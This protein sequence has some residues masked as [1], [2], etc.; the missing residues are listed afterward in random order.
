MGCFSSLE[1]TTF[2]SPIALTSL[3][4]VFPFVC[5]FCPGLSVLLPSP[6]FGH[7]PSVHTHC[8]KPLSLT[9]NAGWPLDKHV[10][11]LFKQCSNRGYMQEHIILFELLTV[12][13]ELY[14]D[15][16]YNTCVNTCSMSVSTNTFGNN[17]TQQSSF[18]HVVHGATDLNISTAIRWYKMS[19]YRRSWSTEDKR[20]NF[21]NPL[22]SPLVRPA[23]WNH[24]FLV[25][26]LNN[27]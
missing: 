15:I 9:R 17:I 18:S 26:C 25:K 6:L 14:T 20:P 12:W 22:I 27:H 7:H 21:G 5:I 13:F 2:I 3:L 19:L 10:H 23:G 4:H 11:P 1:N 8:G 24:C 16:S